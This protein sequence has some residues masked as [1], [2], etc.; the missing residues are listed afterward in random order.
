M[1]LALFF[2]TNTSLRLWHERGWLDGGVGIQSYNHWADS[3]ERVYFLT[4]GDERDVQYGKYLRK[5]IMVLPK[6]VR[7]PSLLYSILM[8][9]VYRRELSA[10]DLYFTAQMEGSW[11]AMIAKFMFR[12]KFVLRC[13]FQWTTMDFGTGIGRV[14]K[15]LARI[16]EWC[17]Y[18]AADYIIVTSEFA[19]KDVVGKYRVNAKKVEVIRNPVDTTLFKP[20]QVK[21]KPRSLVF[22]GRLEKE[23][24]LFALLE[25][26]GDTGCSLT[27][28]G[29]GSLKPALASY[30]E[31]H[32]LAVSFRGNIPNNVLPAELNTHEVFILPSLYENSPKALLEAMSCGMPVIGTNV[33]GINEIL[34]HG[35]TGYLCE[36]SAHAIRKAIVDVMTNEPLRITLGHNARDHICKNFNLA[37]KLQKEI[38]IFQSVLGGTNNGKTVKSSLRK[39]SP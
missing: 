38:S 2:T 14:K 25:A 35:E 27:I 10:V 18:H 39:S 37:Q 13:G 32:K 4:Y 29:N 15:V 11:A 8:P 6:K 5:N 12:K 1:K 7:I 31:E 17:A 34:R 21:K 28:I 19:K 22:V 9:F 20:L 24:N 26:L 30:A 23:K 16:L 3:L 36:T 33:L